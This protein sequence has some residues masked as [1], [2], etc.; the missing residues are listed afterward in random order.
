MIDF[1]QMLSL[2]H[3][4]RYTIVYIYIRALIKAT[5]PLALKFKRL[6]LRIQER[7]L[8]I[9]KPF[10]IKIAIEIEMSHVQYLVDD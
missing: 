5:L 10:E 9:R 3:V 7:Q 4:F 6:Q 1:V 2:I 8:W